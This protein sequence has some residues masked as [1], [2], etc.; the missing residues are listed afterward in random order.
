MPTTIHYIQKD[1]NF[2]SLRK[3]TDLRIIDKWY[4]EAKCEIL[5]TDKSRYVFFMKNSLNTKAVEELGTL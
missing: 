1:Y 3:R 5:H 4:F 2:S